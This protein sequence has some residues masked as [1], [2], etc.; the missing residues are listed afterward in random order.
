MY[1]E[2]NTFATVV[3]NPYYSINIL[4]WDTT[5]VIK[6]LLIY[7]EMK[8]SFLFESVKIIRHCGTFSYKV[9]V[10]V[11]LYSHTRFNLRAG[12]PVYIATKGYS[13]LDSWCVRHLV[14][15]STINL[16]PVFCPGSRH[17]C[18]HSIIGDPEH[19]SD[20]KPTDHLDTV[21]PV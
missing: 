21:G 13:Q 20:N 9:P 15:C 4:I 1:N 8:C 2:N 11:N 10:I 19:L 3:I 18:H 6:F 7:N 14:S 16:D 17:G 12:R 5:V